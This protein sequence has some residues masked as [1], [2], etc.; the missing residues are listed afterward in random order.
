MIKLKTILLRKDHWHEGIQRK[1]GTTLTLDAGLIDWLVA[2]DR[3][4]E[5]PA[6]NVTRTPSPPVRRGCCGGRW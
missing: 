5:V 1:P 3:G 6:A 4:D 2:K